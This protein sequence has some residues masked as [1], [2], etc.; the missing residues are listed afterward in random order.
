RGL[1]ALG[2]AGDESHFPG[3]LFV[4]HFRQAREAGLRTIAHAGEAA[5]AESVRQALA[6]VGVTRIG[7]GI[8]SDG[9]ESLLDLIAERGIALEVC[10]TSNVQTSTVP[11]L[12]DHPLPFFL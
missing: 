10:P 5:G 8:R 9:D 12:A 11:S 6:E 1:V 7:H 3:E 4:D 2:L